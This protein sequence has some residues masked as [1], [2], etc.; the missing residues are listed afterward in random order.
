MDRLRSENADEEDFC[1]FWILVHSGVNV[2]R[3]L[4]FKSKQFILMLINVFFQ[5]LHILFKINYA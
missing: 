2:K 5:K 1:L 4:S 3:D